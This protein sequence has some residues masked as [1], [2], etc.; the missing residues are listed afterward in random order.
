MS[1]TSYLGRYFWDIDLKKAKPKSHPEYYIKRILELGDAK[2]FCWLK[3]VFGRKKIK[4]VLE[5]ARISSKSKNYWR[6]FLK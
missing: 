2:A 4:H 1:I 3:I 5:K 6:F